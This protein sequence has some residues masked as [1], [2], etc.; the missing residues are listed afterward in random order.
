[1]YNRNDSKPEEAKKVK[2]LLDNMELLP[3]SKYYLISMR[4]W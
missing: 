1:M 3:A 4:Y 2:R